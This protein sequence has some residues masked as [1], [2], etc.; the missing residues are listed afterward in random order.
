[1]SLF[2]SYEISNGFGIFGGL[3]TSRYY[4]ICLRKDH[5]G[6]N[7][8]RL[9]KCLKK[10]KEKGVLLVALNEPFVKEEDFDTQKTELIH[11]EA[12]IIPTSS[13]TFSIMLKNRVEIFKCVHCN[14]QYKVKYCNGFVE[15]TTDHSYVKIAYEF[16]PFIFEGRNDSFVLDT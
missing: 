5:I 15:I 3:K 6:T 8:S 2:K 10:T 16:A 4:Y 9:M 12:S 1:M 7:E 11:N 14:I 13:N